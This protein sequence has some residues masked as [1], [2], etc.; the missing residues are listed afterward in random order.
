LE[1]WKKEDDK[2]FQKIDATKYYFQLQIKDFL[3]AIIE[4]KYPIETGEEGRKTVG[5]FTAIYRSNR[6]RSPVKFPLQPDFDGRM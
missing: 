6:D 2:H 5:I 3:N 1:K 4:N